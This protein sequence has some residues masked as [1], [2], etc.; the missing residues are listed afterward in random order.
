MGMHRMASSVGEVEKRTVVADLDPEAMAGAG[1]DDK[2]E[3]RR[4][5]P[6]VDGEGK[7]MQKWGK[8]WRLDP[9]EF[10][11][12]G[13]VAAK[14]AKLGRAVVE[15]ASLGRA[16]TERAAPGEN[17]AEYTD[18]S[19]PSRNSERFREGYRGEAAAKYLFIKLL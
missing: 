8:G 10:G 7:L 5:A 13:G 11:G 15:R 3:W 4:G 2:T 1:D 9:D 17:A 16:A 14:R 6:P 18:S 19:F 12:A